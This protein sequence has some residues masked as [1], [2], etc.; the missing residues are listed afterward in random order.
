MLDC[1][2]GELKVPAENPCY[3]S[4]T[5]GNLEPAVPSCQCWRGRQ[6]GTGA[7]GRGR[8]RKRERER[9]RGDEKEDEQVRPTEAGERA[10]TRAGK[11]T[12]PQ[13]EGC[14][15]H[16]TRNKRRR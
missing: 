12:M 1:T 11:T 7:W 9:G 8:E 14:C 4:R 13:T 2:A 5:H 15:H 3:G 6:A 16:E 10:K